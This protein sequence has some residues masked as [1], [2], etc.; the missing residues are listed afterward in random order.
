[1]LCAVAVTIDSIMKPVFGTPVGTGVASDRRDRDADAD[2]E[3]VGVGRVALVLVDQR[4]SRA[5]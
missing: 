1:M 4:R 2:R 3:D 5:G